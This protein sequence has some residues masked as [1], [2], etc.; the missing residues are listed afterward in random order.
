MSVITGLGL[1]LLIMLLGAAGMTLFAAYAANRL[2][3]QPTRQP[4]VALTP[5]EAQQ[6]IEL[7]DNLQPLKEKLRALVI[8]YAP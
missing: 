2:K 8:D 3:Y 1:G 7:I 6:L 4:A 5:E